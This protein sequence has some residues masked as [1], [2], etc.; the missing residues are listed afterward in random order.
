[1]NSIALRTFGLAIFAASFALAGCGSSTTGGDEG[2]KN[3][4]TGATGGDEQVPAFDG[5]GQEK[6]TEAAYPAGPYGVSI[7]SV[8]PNFKFVGFSNAQVDNSALDLIQL[9]DFYN[10]T[11]K[12]T[13]PA[14]SK[15]GASGAAMPTV[16]LI[17][18]ASVWCGPC[19]EEA[20]SVLPGQYKKVQPMGGEFLLNLADGPNPGNSATQKDLY[21]WT[22]KYKVN[23]PAIYDPEYKMGQLF[24]Q[25]AF[26]QNFIVD[27]RTM[28]VCKIIAGAPDPSDTSPG[29]GAAFWSFY[30][31]VA[32]DP[33]ACK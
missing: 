9:S 28:K 19:N 1:M 16:L 24:A 6:T 26:P 2:D 5:V 7:G 22:K 30:E 25:D 10:P 14:N 31:K 17:D 4:S 33:T 21:N 32:S 18:V 29:G 23:Y 20:G 8:V 3:G 11:G 12:G 27:T 13:W 15:F